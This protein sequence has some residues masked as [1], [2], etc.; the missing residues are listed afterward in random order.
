MKE[1]K[2]RFITRN[3]FIYLFFHR[4]RRHWKRFPLE[5][6]DTPSLEVFKARQDDGA[7]GNLI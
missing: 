4:M 7:S 1:C 2:F 5:T 3:L 6:V